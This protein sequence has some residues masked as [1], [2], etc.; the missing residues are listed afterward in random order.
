MSFREIRDLQNRE[1][2]NSLRID[3]QKVLE[4]ERLEELERKKQEELEDMEAE[5]TISELREA[6]LRM[7]DKNYKKE[8][9]VVDP[10]VVICQKFLDELSSYKDVN[11]KIVNPF[12]KRKIYIFSKKDKYTPTILKVIEKCKEKVS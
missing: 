3:Q 6:R 8:E 4:K 11:K 10:M 7:L 12:S 1:Y 5:L 9:K 2:E